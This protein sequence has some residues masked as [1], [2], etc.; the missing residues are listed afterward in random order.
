M[1]TMEASSSHAAARD[2]GTPHIVTDE[3]DLGLGGDDTGAG[4]S[5]MPLEALYQ[6]K[7]ESNVEII[8]A[9]RAG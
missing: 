1:T 7:V 5:A 9:V 6:P 4:N 2:E 3:N 8:E